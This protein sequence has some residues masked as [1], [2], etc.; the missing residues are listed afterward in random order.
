MNI[1]SQ[2]RFG[3]LYAMLTGANVRAH[4]TQMHSLLEEIARCAPHIT[5]DTYAVK[6]RGRDDDTT[7]YTYGAVIDTD[8]IPSP[9][10]RI[11]EQLACYALE[12][13]TSVD[14]H[15]TMDVKQYQTTQEAKTDAEA[16]R[17]DVINTYKRLPNDDPTK[18]KV[19][20]WQHGV[21]SW[22]WNA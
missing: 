2:P 3:S 1:Q 13:L 18:P 4:N 6:K 14:E 10:R 16:E 20:G 5:V 7:R 19:S 15:A 17:Q 9:Y 8:T 11:V 22:D 12:G 21:W